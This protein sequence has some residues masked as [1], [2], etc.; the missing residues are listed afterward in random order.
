MDYVNS[1]MLTQNHV[2]D[3]AFSLHDECVNT[4]RYKSEPYD[5]VRGQVRQFD[6]YLPREMFLDRPIPDRLRMRIMVDLD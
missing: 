4:I 5:T 1:D 6:I 3:L 2:C